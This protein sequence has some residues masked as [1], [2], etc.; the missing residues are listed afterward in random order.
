MTEPAS[1]T[2]VRLDNH[3]QRLVVLE[4]TAAAT[5]RRVDE[6]E[7]DRDS[8]HNLVTTIGLLAVK[9]Q[10]MA[11]SAEGIA[12]RAVT[13]VLARIR[14]EEAQAL[15]D[16]KAARRRSLKEWFG[17]ATAIGTACGVAFGLVNHFAHL[18]F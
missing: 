6:L 4:E 18:L 15:A 2:T 13:K 12:E 14:Q 5:T 11:E 7:S 17:I 16:Q 8:V 3:S 9:V 10:E 1:E